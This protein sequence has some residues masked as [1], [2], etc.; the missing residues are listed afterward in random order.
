MRLNWLALGLVVLATTASAQVR[1]TGRVTNE[2]NAPLDKA[3]VTVRPAAS[4]TGKRLVYTTPTGAFALDLPSPGD[5]VV[6]VEA[7][8]YFRLADRPIS[9]KAGE[10][11]LLLVLSAL[12]EVS[13]SVDVSA[14]TTAVA[15]N[16]ST[17]EERL[18]GK[19]LLD[20]PYPTTQNMKDAMRLLPGVIRDNGGGLHLNGGAE[21]QISYLLDGFN[22]AD[23]LTGRFESRLSVESVQSMEVLSGRF[24][25]EYGKGSAGVLSVNTKLGDDQ[26]RYSATNFIPGL[27][28][29]KGLR[30]G[31]WT[32]RFNVSGPI[33]RGRIWFADSLALQYNQT[34]VRELPS[35]QDTSSSWRYT[36]HLHTQVNLTPSNILHIGFLANAWRSSRDGLSALDPPEAT[37]NRRSN[38]WFADIKDQIYFGRGSLLEFGY[39]SNHTFDRVIPRGDGLYLLTPFGRRGN[40]FINGERRGSRD[41]LLANYFLPG[42]SWNGSHQLKMGIDLNQVGYWQDLHR[43]GYVVLNATDTPLRRVVFGGNGHV[44]RSNYETASY[45]QDSWR[46]RPRLL[47]EI[48]LRAD[49]DNILRNWNVSPRVGL[50]WSPPGRENT[51]ISGG[52][53]ITYDVPNLQMFVRPLDQY[54]II[55]Y[56]PPYGS[57]D[58]P[59]S[60]VY[61]VGRHLSTPRYQTWSATLDQRLPASIYARFQVLRKRGHRGL[62]YFDTFYTPESTTFDLTNGRH[63]IFDSYEVTVRQSIRSQ[64]EWLASYTRSR[65]VSTAVVDLDVDNPLLIAANAGRVPWDAPNRFVSWGYLPAYFRNWAIAYLFETRSGFPFSVQN[66]VGAVVGDINQMRYP[67]FFELDLHVERRFE[68][69]G[70]RW[71]FRFGYYNITN[72]QNP[73]VVNNNI[74]SPQFMTFYGGQA[75]ALNLRIRW[76]GKL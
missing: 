10:N 65:A 26:F 64:Y 50:A 61:T 5:F 69:R 45:V 37:A 30:I 35:G 53:A 49:W 42:F 60:S 23:P 40:Y 56:F 68:F 54:P 15:L 9:L 33:R 8:G 24:S 29:Q 25:A 43:T 11:E 75:R 6:T 52:Y 38:Q 74:D 18:N 41:Q 22:V 62:A 21:E 71:A 76:L 2:N 44:S 1:L 12:R 3:A 59:V 57:P 67:A 46:I 20:V 48:G 36:N 7:A 39:A 55:T 58:C 16:R 70:Q 13:E 73:N 27:E 72:H 34:V 28:S 17:S 51:K 32:P 47:A 63:D 14:S 66:G 19:E 31:G 4:E